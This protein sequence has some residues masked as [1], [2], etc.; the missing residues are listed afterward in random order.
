MPDVFISHASEDKEDFVRPLARSLAAAGLDVWF[1]EFSLRPGDSLRERIDAG[2]RDS[3]IGIVV[4]SPHFFAKRWPRQEL[5]GMFAIEGASDENVIVPVWHNVDQPAVAAASPMVAGRVAILSAPGIA[6][7]AAQIQ[8]AVANKQRTPPGGWRH[9]YRHQTLNI[10]NLPRTSDLTITNLKFVD[11]IIQGPG[12][13]M[14]GRNLTFRYCSFQ[15]RDQFWPLA[16]D[17][18]YVGGIVVGYCFFER[19]SFERLGIAVTASGIDSIIGMIEGDRSSQ[20]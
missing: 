16:D 10:N 8:E 2:L 1:D 3:S 13:M 18:R 6:H 17:R 15:S 9:V 5:E 11:C 14:W 20:T 7:V 12:V 19:C 4:L